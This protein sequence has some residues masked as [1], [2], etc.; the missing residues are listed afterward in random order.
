MSFFFTHE[1]SCTCAWTGS[2]LVSGSDQKISYLHVELMDV[3]NCCLTAVV[4][5][6]WTGCWLEG[7]WDSNAL[8]S[9]PSFGDD[10]E[11]I[12]CP[13]T[14]W[15]RINRLCRWITSNRAPL[16]GQS[17][18]SWPKVSLSVDPL[19]GIFI[20]IPWIMKN[21]KDAPLGDKLYLQRHFQPRKGVP[22]TV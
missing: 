21:S 9:I 4:F 22:L 14:E 18:P 5:S 17:S 3:A 15:W 8:I 2:P 10:L 16:G 12:Y 6:T 19:N 7:I 1:N 20:Q 11:R 13:P